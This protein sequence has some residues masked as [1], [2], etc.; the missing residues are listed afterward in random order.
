MSK[1]DLVIKNGVIIDG[2]GSPLFRADVGI[3]GDSIRS[4]GDL[5]SLSAEKVVDASDLFV[6]PGFID[7]HNH[8]DISIFELP[9]ADNY[10]LQGVTTIV[11]GNCGSS[12]APLSDINRSEYESRMKSVR[13]DVTVTWTS[14]R[15]YLNALEDLRPSINIA[16]LVGHGTIRAAVLGYEDVKPSTKD[17]EVMKELVR[18][19]MEAGA[20][21]LSTG[22]RYVPSMF[23]DKNEVVE[24][25]KVVARYGGIYSTHMRNQGIG[26]IDSVVESIEVGLE[27]GAGIQISHLKASGRASWGKTSGALALISDYAGRGYDVSADAYP[28]E[29]YSMGLLALLPAEYRSGSREEVLKKLRNSSVVEKLKAEFAAEVH[30]EDVQI[31]RSPSNERFEGMRIS[32]I[33]R[34]LGLDPVEA[35]VKLLIEDDLATRIVG[36]TMDPEEVC[37]VVSHPLVAIGSDGSVTKPGVGKPHPRSYGTFPRVIARY[38]REKKILPLSEAVRKM[39]SLPARKLGLWDRGLIRPGLRAD[40]VVF[41]YFT[42]EDTATYADPHRYPSGVKYV[43]VNGRVVVENGVIDSKQGVGAVLRKKL[44]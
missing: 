4:I 23:A 38:V 28:Y 33:A 19:A 24:L 10:I 36:F 16:A 21:G 37:E 18:E 12:P 15:E 42:I 9:T 43:V 44:H 32:Q 20:F 17:L 25:A 22:L 40:I 1:F 2:S 31:A 30:W 26:L 6:A 41:D 8:S 3:V 13:P 11:I 34:E 39:T 35:V 7:I 14:F 27:S 5:E 29:A